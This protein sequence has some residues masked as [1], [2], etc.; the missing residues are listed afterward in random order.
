MVARLLHSARIVRAFVLQN[1]IILLGWV[2][3]Q[4]F[5][6]G[7]VPFEIESHEIEALDQQKL[8]RGRQVCFDQSQMEDEL[9]RVKEHPER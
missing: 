1:I 7:L 4:G 9:E 8:S 2:T 6:K 5:S 3:D